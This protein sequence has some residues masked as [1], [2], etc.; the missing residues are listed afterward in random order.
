MTGCSAAASHG[1]YPPCCPQPLVRA[2]AEPSSVSATHTRGSVSRGPKWSAAHRACALPICPGYRVAGAQGIWACQ[3]WAPP[4]GAIE[5]HCIPASFPTTHPVTWPYCGAWKVCK[6]HQVLQI[7]SAN[8]S[9]CCALCCRLRAGRV[10]RSGQ[11]AA[12]GSRTRRH[13]LVSADPVTHVPP[14]S[15][16][17]VVLRGLRTRPHCKQES[18]LLQYLQCWRLVAI[19]VSQE[20]RIN[21]CSVLRSLHQA[22]CCRGV[23]YCGSGLGYGSS[24]CAS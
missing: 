5:P 20:P 9:Y 16:C 22:R 12:D 7:R 23:P 4:Y 24:C 15:S 10:L 14:P 1:Q 2:W 21:A 13:A 11:A 17:L 8:S 3:V 18:H 6:P 19:A